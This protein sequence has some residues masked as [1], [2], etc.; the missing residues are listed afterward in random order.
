V[1]FWNEWQD[2]VVFESTAATDGGELGR[3][4]RL[5]LSLWLIGAVMYAASILLFANAISNSKRDDEP[6]RVAESVAPASLPIQKVAR[7]E[8]VES[9]P[10]QSTQ[11]DALD[12]V[13]QNSPHAI[14]PEQG[15]GEAP[16][17]ENL[18]SL[19]QRE[20]SPTGE[21]TQG[22]SGSGPN[23]TERV[24]VISEA[25]VRSGPS[26]SAAVIGTAHA[27]AEARVASRDSGWTQIVDPSSGNRGWI[28]S[29][30]LAPLTP[31]VDTASTEGSE[32]MSEDEAAD[33]LTESKPTAKAKKHRSKRHHGRRG[34]AFRFGWIRF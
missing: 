4:K 21:A 25:S 13:A 19:A 18:P 22:P 33:E 15:A 17:T 16:A 34:F 5:R 7:L 2:I 29:T 31:T 28:D 27:G 3:M 8:P 9:A 24:K 32:Q 26:S 10:R 20:Q 23:E 14:S 6:K 30:V 12:P 11:L 1:L